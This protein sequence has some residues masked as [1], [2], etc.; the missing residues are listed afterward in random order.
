MY[1]IDR[2]RIGD[3]FKS[4]YEDDILAASIGIRVGRYRSLAFV[5]GSFFAGIAGA[6]MAHRL[7]AI[8]PHIFGLDEMVYLLVW[9]VAGGTATFAG[10]II[11]VAVMSFLFEWTRPLLEWRPLFFGAI[12][13]GF[14]IFMPGGLESLIPKFTRLFGNRNAVPAKTEQPAGAKEPVV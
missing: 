6:L 5:L 13:I 2:S 11:G 1:R 3:T 12:L 7:N 14:L 9:V 4:I 8:D 10:P